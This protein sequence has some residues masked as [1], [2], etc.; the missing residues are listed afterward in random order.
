MKLGA[1]EGLAIVLGL[2]IALLF[3]FVAA[4]P[5]RVHT[6]CLNCTEA[7]QRAEDSK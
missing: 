5:G 6:N 1:G 7:L 2:G 3:G 4:D